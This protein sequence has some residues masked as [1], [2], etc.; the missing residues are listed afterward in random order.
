VL[1]V[2]G[3]ELIA[4][5]GDTKLEAGDHVYVFFH[6]SDRGFIELLFGRPM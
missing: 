5:K 6:D 3:N 1:I 2:R 4:A